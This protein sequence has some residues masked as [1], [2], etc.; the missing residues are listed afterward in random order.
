MKLSIKDSG[1]L[2]ELR[3]KSLD[4]RDLFKL[5]TLIS[6]A[7]LA[8][9]IKGCAEIDTIRGV[10]M[11]VAGRGGDLVDGFVARLLHQESDMGA[12]VDTG[13]DKLGMTAIIGAA[14][15]KDA[16]PK[17]ILATIGGKQVLNASLTA[18]HAHR[19]PTANFRPTK[20]GKQA[21]FAD[22]I[23]LASYLYANAFEHERPD[24]EMH[25]QF[26]TLGNTA[27]AAGVALSIPAT[28]TYIQRAVS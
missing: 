1:S 14:W 5:P 6:A 8:T 20:A 16:V 7:S 19:H 13:F 24:L 9:V 21:M 3:E 15:H 2:Q 18:I 22:N 17:P 10:N 26:R 11:V 4:H 28:T 12:L 25:D 23:A 27:L